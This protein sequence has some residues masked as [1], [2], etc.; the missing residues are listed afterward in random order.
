[1]IPSPTK[2]IS[3]FIFWKGKKKKKELRMDAFDQELYADFGLDA[4]GNPIVVNNNGN[5]PMDNFVFNDELFQAID[6]L[7]NAP[8][9]VPPPVDAYDALL[10]E[11][12]NRPVEVFNPQDVIDAVARYNRAQ[13]PIPPPSAAE[14]ERRN[15]ILM[16]Y[17]ELIDANDP[18]EALDADYVPAFNP[19]YDV[20]VQWDE[21][22]GYNTAAQLAH[23]DRYRRRM[24]ALLW[25]VN[26]TEATRLMRRH[27]HP[28][29]LEERRLAR[30]A[31]E[32]PPPRFY[33]E[34]IEMDPNELPAREEYPNYRNL[35]AENE[36]LK[37]QAKPT[38]IVTAHD[39]PYGATIEDL[40]GAPQVGEI[41]ELQT[42]QAAI[43]QRHLVRIFRN[44]QV[45]YRYRRY[46]FGAFIAPEEYE[47]Q[48]WSFAA[49]IADVVWQLVNYCVYNLGGMI[50][51]DDLAT[52]IASYPDFTNG[53]T[54][55][56]TL[57]NTYWSLLLHN[58]NNQTRFSGFDK[59]LEYKDV[60]RRVQ[61]IVYD[62]FGDVRIE[63]Q[64]VQEVGAGPPNQMEADPTYDPIPN[65]PY[66]PRRPP[67]PPLNVEIP[68]R[69]IHN[70]RIIPI[71]RP[72]ALEEREGVIDPLGP[73]PMEYDNQPDWEQPEPPPAPPGMERRA[74]LLRSN[75]EVIQGQII[76]YYFPPTRPS[77]APETRPRKKK[78]NQLVP[79]PNA[80][81]QVLPPAQMP[82]QRQDDARFRNYFG[83][84]TFTDYFGGEVPE[85]A[86]T[87]SSIQTTTT[88]STSTSS[89][90]PAPPRV[91]DR[92]NFVAGPMPEVA[93][94]RDYFEPPAAVNLPAPP[95]LPAPPK[96]RKKKTRVAGY[97]IC[98]NPDQP[99]L[100]L[101]ENRSWEI[102][103][104][105]S[106]SANLSPH[107]L[108]RMNHFKRN[109]TQEVTL[110]DTYIV[111]K[112][113]QVQVG[114][115]ELLE[116]H[117]TMFYK[118]S[119]M[120]L[121]AKNGSVFYN[122]ET[123]S[124]SCF[125]MSFLRA[126]CLQYEFDSDCNFIQM[127][128]DVF[129]PE[130]L[131]TLPQ[132]NHLQQDFSFVRYDVQEADYKLMLF[133]TDITEHELLGQLS[134]M[135]IG[136]W[137][138]A[139][140]ELEV[141]IKNQKGDWIDVN[142]LHTVASIV[143][144]LF[145]VIV[146]I[147]DVQ[148]SDERAWIFTPDDN[149][150]IG[151][152]LQQQ[153]YKIRIISLLYDQG[154]MIPIRDIRRFFSIHLQNNL[155]RCAYC[156]FCEKRG[157]VELHSKKGIQLHLT[158]CMKKHF[159]QYWNSI[160]HG[161]I[162]EQDLVMAVKPIKMNYNVEEHQM[163]PYCVYCNHPV[164]QQQFLHHRCFIAP[165]DPPK[166]PRQKENFYV[167]DIEAGQVF[168][169]HKGISYHV[170]NML[171][172]RKMYPT[173]EEEKE[174]LVFENEY[175]FM[176]HLMS[177]E[178]YENAVIIAHNGGSYDH[179]FIV[180]YLERMKI[181]HSFIPTPN[182]LHKFLSVTVEEKKMVFLDFIHFMPGSLKSISQSMG[183]SVS[184]GD[185]PHRFNDK[186]DISYRGRI[187]PIL[188]E[189]DYW[190][191]NT[192]KN[193][194]DVNELID[195]YHEQLELFCVCEEPREYTSHCTHCP[196]CQKPLWIMR[197]QMYHY[198]KLDV[199]VLGEACARYRDEL[200]NFEST[201]NNPLG[202]T[203]PWSPS[204]IEPFDFMTVPQL[205]MQILLQ[206]FAQP[207]FRN[208]M[209]KR[210][211]GQTAEGLLWVQEIERSTGEKIYHRQNHHREYYDYDAHMFADGYSEIHNKM[212][213][214]LDCDLYACEDCHFH[215][216][217]TLENH[218]RFPMRTYADV[219]LKT[220]STIE[221]LRFKGA[222][223]TFACKVHAP[224]SP[225]LLK[226]LQTV[227]MAHFFYG[228]RTEVFQ[229]YRKIKGEE[230]IEYY[231]VCS[232]Y[233]YVCAFKELPYD[234]PEY[235]PGYEVE[236]Y[237]LF[238]NDPEIKY[239]GF[240][241]A[242]VRPNPDCL[243]GL[244]PNRSEEGRL[245]FTVET[246][247]G[248]WGLE[249]MELAVHQGYFIEEIYEVIH[250]GPT[251]RSNQLFRGYVDYFLKMKQEAEGWTKLGGS[252]EM[253]E[254][255]KDTLIEQLFQSNGQIGRIEK[256]N[257]TKNP[258]RRALAK[259][260][261]NSL[262]GKFA[263]KPKA[264]K[265]GVI[266][267]ANEFIR[268]W[269]NPTIEKE[270]I[271]FRETGVGIFKYQYQLK[272]AYTPENAKGNIFLA[273]KVTEH[274]R[275]ILHAQMIKIGPER[276]LYCDTDSIIFVWSRLKEDLTG[277]GLGKWTNEY[278]TKQIKEFIA[279]APKFYMLVFDENQSSLKVKGIQLTTKNLEILSIHCLKQ[280]LWNQLSPASGK[281]KSDVFVDHMTIY[282]NCHNGAGLQYGVMMTR[283]AKKIVQFVITK[284][285]LVTDNIPS[286]IEELEKVTTVPIG[287]RSVV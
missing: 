45:H 82:V 263:Q 255:Q 25:N 110:P 103:Q 264:K 113:N 287:H 266:Y 148:T 67:P 234:I 86:L 156:P 162:R 214:C 78:T 281:R 74:R 140:R 62:F 161:E 181:A 272:P 107:I 49:D 260:F 194:E 191:L 11:V 71:D 215:K 285:K 48:D 275:C 100:I 18:A 242:K 187:P 168:I 216:I 218:P 243:L 200:L 220:V 239:W 250:W 211:L 177:R 233:P 158:A 278:P 147:F 79:P 195:F 230:T 265:Q 175:D 37:P 36:V 15:R 3:F 98:E 16:D 145:G 192:K 12:Y 199:D 144:Q 126:Q 95:P 149:V 94:L 23:Y 108:K 179:H 198:C 178:E 186:E 153:D 118:K 259:L 213:F 189:K 84:P 21:I 280:L 19:I 269:S 237:R 229:P 122:P 238:H 274:A 104:P 169:P 223:V 51:S 96:K 276:I 64:L 127:Q 182:S 42:I 123:V 251:Q 93:G 135:E 61:K 196:E 34:A 249:E 170:C 286:S 185:F 197:E 208:A 33:V 32:D 91:M 267:S 46:V 133:R 270:S 120:R 6:N 273:A 75:S 219:W 88:S 26:R 246:M 139:A 257:V 83:P 256:Q 241:R 160:E 53:I 8:N 224:Q 232:L 52:W 90:R 271:L 115:Y 228:G 47:G 55:F 205:A 137:E 28:R 111:L 121:Y 130:I 10:N 258:I 221:L 29:N 154:H 1:M 207:V 201:A 235:I 245:T 40:Q 129:S 109:S 146:Q 166:E 279:L 31:G 76:P 65:Y 206:G 190:C 277:I 38:V 70:Y 73:D 209:D 72:P 164:S 66:P 252:N 97:D 225:Y 261:L 282:S 176:D 9:N 183:L 80:V 63:L 231:D 132:W 56:P 69:Y 283:Y 99:F 17:M 105:P 87:S 60:V 184:K 117:T 68:A 116:Q 227:P 203:I 20:P 114:A 142:D 7:G 143:S 180:R 173:T 174:G 89:S 2:K 59:G 284:R 13:D 112:D 217:Q 54:F 222:D 188:T 4:Q 151:T 106:S 136:Y 131:C 210:R 138:L 204:A 102:A 157:G 44:Q 92:S 236:P 43:P 152:L 81:R 254:D 253:S 22:G 41:Y 14:L 85:P 226:C 124:Y 24:I 128:E 171:V 39:Y 212:Y 58:E 125:L 77:Y 155:R 150:T 101:A 159:R 202:L 134:P 5:E 167:Y 119:I 193:K 27:Q 248:C 172:F 247:E 262:W 35:E 244:L 50:A 268:I 163:M 57:T 240:I 141:Y 165:K 30:A